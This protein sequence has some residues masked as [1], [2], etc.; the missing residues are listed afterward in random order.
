MKALKITGCSDS[1]M[2]YARHIGSVVPYIGED[3]DRKGPIYWSREP[4][5]YKNIVFQC[6]AE[7]IEVNNEIS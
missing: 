2:W 5:G 4:A 1:Q 6:D 3:I 7:L